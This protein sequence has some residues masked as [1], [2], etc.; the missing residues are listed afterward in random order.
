MRLQQLIHEAWLSLDEREPAWRAAATVIEKDGEV[1]LLK[2]GSTAPW[3]PGKWNLPGGNL[4]P[5][6]NAAKAAKR[7]AGEEIGLKLS[8]LRKLQKLSIL[9]GEVT[10]FHATK[11][12]GKPKLGW[13]SSEFR[14]V[15]LEKAVHY[16]L[17]PGVGQALG[18][19]AYGR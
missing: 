14:W 9:G 16:D 8:A 4:E 13:E 7:E 3:M 6:E 15:P 10:Y 5:G 2:R 1:L 12:S 11:F 17:I 19:L 18:A